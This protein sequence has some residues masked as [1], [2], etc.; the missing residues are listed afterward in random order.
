MREQPPQGL[1]ELLERLGLAT[2]SEVGAM[3][4]RV[5]RLARDLPL[6]ES[7]WVDALAQARIL[8]PFQAKEINAGRGEALAVGPYVL[9]GPLGWPGYA[10]FYRAHERASRQTVRLAVIDP[11]ADDAERITA[12]LQ[13]LAAASATIEAECLAPVRQVGVDGDRGWAASDPIE[14]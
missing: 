14:G 4:R 8:T 7:V 13:V 1:I 3:R 11:L 9:S 5:R 12:S 2:A 6:F 10:A